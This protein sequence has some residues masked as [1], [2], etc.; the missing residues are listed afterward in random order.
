LNHARLRISFA[1]LDRA[2]FAAQRSP[3]LSLAACRA[4]AG[5]AVGAW[6][7]WEANLARGLLDDLAARQARP[8][9]E[10]ERRRE[11]EFRGALQVL[12]KQLAALAQ[13]GTPS[14]ARAAQA[15]KL[16]TQRDALLAD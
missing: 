4:R 10:A 2:A 15:A 14:D 11:Q 7:A 9:T 16:R 6:Q 8:L 12:D 3:L 5:L 1:D 13:P